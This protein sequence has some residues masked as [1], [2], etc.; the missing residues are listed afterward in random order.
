[1]MRV[2]MPLLRAQQIQTPPFPGYMVLLYSQA[3]GKAF[4]LKCVFTTVK[5]ECTLLSSS[6]RVVPQN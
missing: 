2:Q 1:M 5:P 6:I 4:Y 3:M